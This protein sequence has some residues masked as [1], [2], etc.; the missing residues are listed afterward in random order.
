MALT[1]SANAPKATTTASTSTGQVVS[2]RHAD[3]HRSHE[4]AAASRWANRGSATHSWRSTASRI[5]RSYSLIISS[6]SV[7]RVCPT[8]GWWIPTAAGQERA[9]PAPYS[10]PKGL[11]KSRSMEGIL[12]PT[13]A[14]LDGVALRV[15][16]LHRPAL[17]DV[18]DEGRG[19][20]HADQRPHTEPDTQFDAV[21]GD[22][23]NSTM[24]K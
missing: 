6:R 15:T 5:R 9:L 8:Y 12:R 23:E 3:A 10:K 21:D 2:L 11:A 18:V 19:E 7:P 13:M 16:R 14:Y 22:D 17:G 24:A 4:L 20:Q 1:C